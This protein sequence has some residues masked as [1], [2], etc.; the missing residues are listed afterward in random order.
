MQ[1]IMA[2]GIRGDHPFTNEPINFDKVPD[3]CPVCHRA[4]SAQIEHPAFCKEGSWLEI[5]YRC[6]HLACSRGFV[7]LY[8]VPSSPAPTHIDK[9]GSAYA[10]SG[11]DIQSG[12]PLLIMIAT[13]A[14]G[15][16]QWTGFY[17]LT[18][19]AP[20]SFVPTSFSDEILKISSR[21]GRIY[22]QAEE[23]DSYGLQEV[24]GP[25]FRKALEFLIKDYAIALNPSKDESIRKGHLGAVIST[26]LGKTKVEVV[27]K[28][29]AWI[30]NDE[31][32]YERKWENKDLSDLKSLIDLT[33][34][35]IEAE[36]LTSALLVE[37][38]T[39][40]TPKR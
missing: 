29:A 18:S 7:A 31:T 33:V 14:R 36:R 24:S 25:G 39:S 6:P 35:H 11:V 38:P 4:I 16:Q 37:M 19:C 13:A 34:H 22:G 5:F 21:F 32:H 20:N 28:R 9:Q 30:G 26:Y 10:A 15:A 2:N 27:A 8:T 12:S 40:E 17:R 23:A 1:M 3:E